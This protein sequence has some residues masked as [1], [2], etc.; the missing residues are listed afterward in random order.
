MS[1]FGYLDWELDADDQL[2]RL[3]KIGGRPMPRLRYVR[4]DK[5]LIYEIDRLRRIVSDDKITFGIFDSAAYGCN[6]KAEDSDV[7][8]EFFRAQRQLRIGNILL[9]HITKSGDNNDQRPFGSTF[10]H[11]SSRCTWYLKRDTADEGAVT[12]GAFCRK[13]NLGPLHRPV[14]IRINYGAEQTH[15]ERVDLATVPELAGGLS[16]KQRVR[17][18]IRS[19]P[20][21]IAELA[22]ELG[23]KLNSVEQAVNRGKDTFTK[24]AGPDGIYR[25]ALLD[26]RRAS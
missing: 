7:A 8:M 6:G 15:F 25:I 13:N 1:T 14:G 16:I 22:T 26:L 5:P 12:L 19:T 2:P 23:V 4:C 3:E 20:K 11:N 24:V 17:A 18:S 10:W 21:T 9:A